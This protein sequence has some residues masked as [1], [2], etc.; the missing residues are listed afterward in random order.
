MRI[1]KDPEIRRQEIID[2]ARKLF[3]E[4]GYEKTSI[5]DIVGEMNVAKGL[6]YYY[7]P[8]KEAILSAIADQLVEEITITFPDDLSDSKDFQIIIQQIL[9]F[10][11]AAIKKNENLLNIKTNKGTVVALHVRQRLENNAIRQVSNL[12]T[13]HPDLVSLKY[14]EY[15]VR[16]LIN[17]LGNLYLEGVQDLEVLTSLIEDIL[18]LST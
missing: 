3:I 12:L 4:K 11:L 9:G 18:G 17:G 16:I 6:F 7:F 8:K 5:D 15:T 13:E 14:P 2:T 1:S 10:Y